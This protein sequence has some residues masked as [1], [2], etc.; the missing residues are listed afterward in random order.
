[1]PDCCKAAA[2]VVDDVV[3]IFDAHGKSEERIGDAQLVPGL[4]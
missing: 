4:A 3:H 1:V 2:Q